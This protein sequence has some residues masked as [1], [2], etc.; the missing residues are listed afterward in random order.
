MVPK[1]LI[2]FVMRS[3]SSVLLISF[4]LITGMVQAQDSSSDQRPYNLFNPTPRAALREF[5]IDR[6]DITESPVSVDPGHFQFEGDLIKW[7]GE[8]QGNGLSTISL[9]NGLYKIGLT[10]S[11]DLQIGFEAYNIRELEEPC[12]NC[13]QGD[14]TEKGTGNAT[15]RL[16]HNFWGNDGN[17]RTAFGMIPYVTLLKE[18]KQKVYG[19]GFPFSYG[20]TET[21]DLGAQAQ[22]DFNPGPGGDHELS[23]FQ[24]IVLG[25]ELVGRLDFYAE[26]MIIFY[27][28]NTFIA[29]NGGLIYNISP[30]VK[31]DLAANLG[32]NEGTP[33][34]VYLGL[35]FRI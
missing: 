35:S 18:S 11:W 2:K 17:T 10:H 20:L 28:S 27:D 5:S 23:Y 21:L 15:L 3:I 14:A 22:F 34:R 25:G 9:L 24:T 30:N 32:L 7:T 6:P 13:G 4:L 16:K 31:L 8:D 33:T 1:T 12:E 29:A 26:G 19:I